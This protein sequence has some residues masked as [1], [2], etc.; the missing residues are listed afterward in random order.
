MGQGKILKN[1]RQKN[2]M[3]QE[4]IAK[5]IV[6]TSYLSRIENGKIDANEE[7]MALLFER[8][9]VDYFNQQ[10]EDSTIQKLLRE[11]EAPLLDNDKNCTRK[12]FEALEPLLSEM[13]PLPLQLEF[14]VKRIRYFLIHPD[15][16]KA[17]ESVDFSEE[18]AEQ[19]DSRLRFLFHKHIGNYYWMM[20]SDLGSS[21]YHFDKA[22][23]EYS[24][25]HFHELEKA[26]L[27]FLYS[28]VLYSQ[29]KES[30]CF[31]NAEEALRIF[32][33]HYRPKQC[34]KVHIQLGICHSR[35]GDFP[36]CRSHYEKARGLAE[37][38]EDSKHLGIIEH[39]FANMY[40]RMQDYERAIGHLKEALKQKEEKTESFAHSFVL[41]LEVHYEKNEYATCRELLSEYDTL[42]EDLPDRLTPVQEMKFFHHFLIFPKEEWEPFME[43]TFFPQLEENRD[44]RKVMKYAKILADYYET[45]GFYKKASHYYRLALRNSE[46]VIG[47]R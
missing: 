5:S 12:T 17:R 1:L 4:E 31:Y 40:V 35:V 23:L 6:S 34:M 41:L 14:H 18:F 27:H 16:E 10:S 39:N 45:K 25:V 11:W 7:T 29:K 33:S 15:S 46:H 21:E 22:M 24:G 30:L 32:Q 8:V 20:T 2:K 3:S 43:K 37:F 47:Y 28:L 42:M 19:L 26:D 44:S 36:T 38:L 9:G 13:T